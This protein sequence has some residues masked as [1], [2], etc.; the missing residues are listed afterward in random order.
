MIDLR[1]SGVRYR[2][3]RPLNQGAT[4]G[5]APVAA[6]FVG[7]DGMTLTTDSFHVPSVLEGRAAEAT[8]RVGS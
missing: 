7:E 5:G 3:S 2:Q 4:A 8:G 6:R 1:R